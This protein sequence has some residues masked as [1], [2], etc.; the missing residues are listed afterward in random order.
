[1]KS[2]GSRTSSKRVNGKLLEAKNA[3]EQAKENAIEA[4]KAKSSF[5]ANMSHEIRTPL[6]G[7]I[8][9]SEVLSDTELTATQKDYVDTIET[10]SQ[11]LLSLINDILDFSKIESGMLQINPHSTSIRETIYDIASIVAPKVKRERHRAKR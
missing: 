4:S 2:K 3:A 8:G 10:S 6:N 5:L 7:V 11:L 9:I 1:M